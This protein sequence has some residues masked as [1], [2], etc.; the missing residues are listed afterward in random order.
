[1]VR[2]ILI[3]ALLLLAAAC[4]GEAPAPSAATVED[5]GELWKIPPLPRPVSLRIDGEQVD[6][7]VLHE[8]LQ[9]E[10]TQHALQAEDPE[11]LPAWQQSFYA[12]PESLLAPLVRDWLLLREHRERFPA[13]I[14]P[15]ALQAFA[16]QFRAQAGAAA[17]QL[18]AR[19]GAEALQAHLERQ[20][21]VQQ[22]VREFAAGV[23][24]GEDEIRA[25]W[26]ERLQRQAADGEFS[27]EELRAE[28]PLEDPQIR[29]AVESELLKHE[30]ET[31]IDAWLG[32]LL[33]V[34]VVEFSRPGAK[35]RVLDV[36]VQSRAARDRQE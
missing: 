5:A 15:G 23:S 12:Q 4:S 30:A 6:E 28:L 21:R 27:I 26:E 20:F 24:F 36:P 10:W 34:T 33:P 3:P 9:D 2:R 17:K 31:A 7:F 18:E 25:A 32:D 35:P 22:M 1:M 19:I 14:D 16:A 8:F 11:D 13:A 29:A